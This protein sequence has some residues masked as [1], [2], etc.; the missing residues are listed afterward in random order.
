MH[1]GLKIAV[2]PVLKCELGQKKTVS[3]HPVFKYI[4]NTDITFGVRPTSMFTHYTHTR[5][6]AHTHTHTPYILNLVHLFW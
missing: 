1:G 3:H 4:I 6:H 2:A 5:T